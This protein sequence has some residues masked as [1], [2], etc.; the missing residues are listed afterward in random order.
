MRLFS[1]TLLLLLLARTSGAQPTEPAPERGV[2][3]GMYSGLA[4][5]MD[6]YRPQTPNGVGIVYV[7]GSGFHTPLGYDAQPITRYINPYVPAFT[8]AGYTV[9]VI[10]HR[11]APRFRYPAAV[12]DVQRAVR[13]VRHHAARYGIATPLAARWRP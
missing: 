10:N 5:L 2:V 8:R 11:S 1:V 9:F 7:P 6:I 12:E 3:Y 4:L 13:F